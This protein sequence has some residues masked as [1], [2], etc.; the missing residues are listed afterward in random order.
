MESIADK[1]FAQLADEDRRIREAGEEPEQM[2]S[3]ADRIFAMGRKAGLKEGRMESCTVLSE[4]T[5]KK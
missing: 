2:E 4:K 5:M 3:I 1:I